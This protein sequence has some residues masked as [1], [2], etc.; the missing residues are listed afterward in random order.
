MFTKQDHK[1]QLLTSLLNYPTPSAFAADI[2]VYYTG[3]EITTLSYGELSIC[4]VIP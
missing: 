2:Y 4:W 1:Q 3:L